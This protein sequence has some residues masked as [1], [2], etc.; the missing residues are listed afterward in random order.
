MQYCKTVTLRKRALAKGMISFYLDY[1]PAYRDTVTMKSIRHEYLGIYIYENPQ[2]KR[3]REHNEIMTEKAEAIRCRRYEAI[4]NER[5]DFFDKAKMKGD[6]LA[7]FKQVLQNKNPKWKFVYEHFEYFVGGKCSCEEVDF[8]L[9]LKFREYLLTAKNLRTGKPIFINS[10]ATYWST[11]RGFINI[12]YR[13]K[14]IRTNPNDYLDKIKTVPVKKESLSLAEL[15]KLYRTP[16]E[17][18][19]LK[20]ASIFACLTGMRRSD[21]I[22]LT[23]DQI[24]KYADGGK[25]VDFY[26]QKTKAHNVIPISDEAYNLICKNKS[27]VK[28]GKV[29]EG[30]EIEMAQHPLKSW[31]RKAG[32][33]KRITFHS[34]RHTF[35]SLQVELGTDLYTVMHLLA[36]KS[37]TT[38]QIYTC[39]AD[40]KSREAASRI[41]SKVFSNKRDDTT[42]KKR[43]Y[44][45]KNQ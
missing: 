41:S 27:N 40:P 29:F 34:F 42:V 3:E 28:N 11:F 2:N 1:Y 32:I 22:N 25:Y 30:F 20:K 16:C 31:L 23:W 10:S 24:N 37:V 35:A 18:D 38:T 17:I 19:V 7:Y 14:M 33:K 21:I 8:D 43:K 26:T 44:T 12:A 36:H 15:R 9:C 5:Y 4:V 13:D 39:H 6:F 45:K